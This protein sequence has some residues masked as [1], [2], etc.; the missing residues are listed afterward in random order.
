MSTPNP[1]KKRKA[2]KLSA[3]ARF[4]EAQTQRIVDVITATAAK[5]VEQAAKEQQ[6][7]EKE[8]VAAVPGYLLTRT[9]EELAELFAGIEAS[10]GKSARARIQRHNLRPPATDAVLQRLLPPEEKPLN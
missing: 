4:S 8:F 5:S 3:S 1:R 10:V 7:A 6:A 2:P 9:D